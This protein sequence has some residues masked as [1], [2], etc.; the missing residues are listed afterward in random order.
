MGSFRQPLPITGPRRDGQGAFGN[1]GITVRGPYL[2][3]TV[4]G[5]LRNKFFES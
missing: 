3:A 2:V 1:S 5:D 4:V